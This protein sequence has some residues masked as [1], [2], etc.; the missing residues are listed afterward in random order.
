MEN[1]LDLIYKQAAQGLKSRPETT[2]AVHLVS[3]HTKYTAF[4]VVNAIYF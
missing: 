4:N 1:L 3:F 2:K